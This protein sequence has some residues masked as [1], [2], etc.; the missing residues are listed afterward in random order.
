MSAHLSKYDLNTYRVTP[1]FHAHIPPDYP[2]N[3]ILQKCRAFRNLPPNLRELSARAKEWAIRCY[4][5]PAGIYGIERW[6]DDGGNELNPSTGKK[7]TNAEIDA[8]W[9]DEWLSKKLDKL[10]VEDIPIPEGG[11]ADPDTWDEPI[12]EEVNLVDRDGL[13]EEGIANDVSSLGLERTA[14]EYGIPSS[15]LPRIKNGKDMARAVLGM[16]GKPWP[17]DGDDTGGE[18][19]KE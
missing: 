18:S 13:T 9:P 19:V 5:N 1:Y 15:W 3:L 11:F 7:M 12:E 14:R 8:Q 17:D 4:G 10:G 16:H 2:L 6:Y